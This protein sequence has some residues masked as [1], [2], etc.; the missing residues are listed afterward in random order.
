MHHVL[1][2]IKMFGAVDICR[3]H[4]V[5]PLMAHLPL[6]CIPRPEFRFHQCAT[7]HCPEA[8]SADV[9]FGIVTH[10]T[11][12]PVDGIFA[13]RLIRVMIAGEHQFQMT[14]D[15]I[16]L[17]QNGD[18]LTRKRHYMWSTHFCAT[19]RETDFLNR[20]S[21]GG[22]GPDFVSEIYL[23]PAG[24]TQFTG[25][26]KQ[27]QSQRYRQPRKLPSL[28]IVANALKQFGQPF[29]RQG[30]IVIFNWRGSDALQM[31]RRIVFG[32]SLLYGVTHDVAKLLPGTG[33]DFQ[34]AFILDNFQ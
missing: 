19:A 2:C 20:F 8:V 34:K 30:G 29:Q 26:D 11:Q 18:S 7:G 1:A 22:N 28:L 9:G 25:T 23:A 33:R 14:G 24:E 21:C 13:H 17:L 5:T 31:Q 12:R 32:Q 27:M 10:Q 4:T 3:P 16:Y 15:F 6:N